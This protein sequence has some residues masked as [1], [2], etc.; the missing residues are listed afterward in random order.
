VKATL[1]VG[2]LAEVVYV[3][4]VRLRVRVR[5]RVRSIMFCYGSIVSAMLSV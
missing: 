4:N 5:V 3:N 1:V 2:L